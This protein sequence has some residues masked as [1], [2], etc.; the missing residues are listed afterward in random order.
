MNPPRYLRSRRSRTALAILAGAGIVAAL[1]LLVKCGSEENE[2]P[3][4]PDGSVRA[5]DHGGHSHPASP[6]LDDEEQATE[7]DLGV[8]AMPPIV[9]AE[10]RSGEYRL[11]AI[12]PD[13]TDRQTV[14]GDLG[15]F[16]AWS[17]DGELL[18]YIGDAVGESQRRLAVKVLGL[19]GREITDLVAG[20]QVPSHPTFG[21]RGKDVY[22]QSNQE[23]VTHTTGIKPFNTLD[24][25]ELRDGRQRTII[26]G[27][28]AVYQ[29]AWSPDGRHLALV[30]GRL[31]CKAERCP[32]T[33]D[34]YGEDLRGA[35]PLVSGG[36][37]GAPAWSPDGEL[38]AFT[39]Q[40]NRGS[41][42]WTARPDGT[43]LARVTDR[44]AE[45]SEPAFS[46]DGSQL[47]FSR[48]C[49]L[50][51]QEIP[52]GSPENLTRSPRVCEISPTWRGD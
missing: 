49:D 51:I 2:R 39:W 35:E 40:T 23:V 21:P 37:A 8:H 34:I 15:M 47:V 1:L 14:V 41:G 24:A 17:S 30:R 44:G 46:P 22:Y 45:D 29:P 3:A 52:G 31:G 11:A 9:F 12:E 28:G 6:D 20:A 18:A 36:V 4:T 27:G 43:G 42:I 10:D 25:I 5:D 13:G 16:P 33:V 50:F 48:S 26:E 7:A 32:Q 19:K 38:V